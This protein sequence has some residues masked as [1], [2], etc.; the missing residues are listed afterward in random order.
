ME[1]ETGV[2]AEPGLIVVFAAGKP[3]ALSLRACAGAVEIGRAE[4]EALGCVDSKVSR[5][6]AVVQREGDAWRIRDRSSRNGTYVDGE[7]IVGERVVPRPRVLRVGETLCGPSWDVR[8]IEREAVEVRG[9]IV[10]GPALRSCL[11][12]IARAAQSGDAV[13]VTGETGTGKELAARHFHE[14]GPRRSGPFVAINCAAV[15]ASLA[16]R[17]FFG[18]RRGTYSG[19]DADADGYVQAANEGTLFL[20]EIGELDPAVRA[21]L[22][23]VIETRQ[24]LPLGASRPRPV[25]FGLVSATHAPLRG[26]VEEGRF[27]PDL[28]F[29]IARPAVALPPLRAR[30]EEIAALVALTLAARGATAHAS[31]V[32]AA[33]LR[34]WPGNVRELVSE[35]RAAAEEAH[36]LGASIVKS[37]HLAPDAGTRRSA[38]TSERAAAI[39]AGAPAADGADATSHAAEGVLRP[40]VLAALHTER[41]NITAAARSLGLHRTQLR[42]LLARWGVE[43]RSFKGGEAA[44][45]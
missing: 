8:P 9:E 16:E 23:R 6:H 39:R 40:R 25:S 36:A 26:L 21:K 4:L 38:L 12:R 14:S 18:V 1:A 22:L 20:D 5:H 44:S 19:A 7:R 29:R 24:V 17:L 41:G 32:E 31:L 43:A 28:F 45:E 10:V 35:V 33:L 27:R 11:D 2:R 3:R 37:R 42:R 15:P 30:P 13:H 34:T